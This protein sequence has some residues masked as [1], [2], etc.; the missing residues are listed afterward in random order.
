[1]YTAKAVYLLSGRSASLG[2]AIACALHRRFPTLDEDGLVSVASRVPTIY[3]TAD[4]ESELLDIEAARRA[5]Y[6][7]AAS[8]RHGSQAV[9][10]SLMLTR[11]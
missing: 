9:L 4:L 11:F 6:L 8:I 1:M 2:R 3:I 7:P 5:S 10:L